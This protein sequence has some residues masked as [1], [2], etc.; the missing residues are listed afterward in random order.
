MGIK[1]YKLM[2]LLNRK[3]MTRDDLRKKI[4][5]SSATMTKLSKNEYVSLKVVESICRELNCQP[6]DIMEYIPEDNK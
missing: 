5:I 2:D 1:F 3:D 4:G 6:G